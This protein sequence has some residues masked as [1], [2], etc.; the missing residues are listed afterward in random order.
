M[1]T[2][3]SYG[4]W[5]RATGSSAMTLDG[6]VADALLAGVDF[7]DYTDEQ[8]EAVAAA[9]RAAINEA[10]P[11]GVSLCGDEF[12]GP[13]YQESPDLAEIV[14]SVDFWAVAEAVLTGN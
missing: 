12:Y 6:E 10:L 5:V 11:E 9:Y 14:D 13:A 2:N 7:S 8:I 4:S 1:T 3:R